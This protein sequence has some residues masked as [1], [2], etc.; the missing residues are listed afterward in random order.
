MS[1]LDWSIIPEGKWS[2]WR[3]T[4]KWASLDEKAL[5]PY[6]CHL[7][8]KANPATE[9]GVFSYARSGNERVVAFALHVARSHREVAVRDS[10]RR[11]LLQ[12]LIA[13]G[14][15]RRLVRLALKCNPVCV[16]MNDVDGENPYHTAASVVDGTYVEELSRPIRSRASVRPFYQAPCQLLPARSCD[17]RNYEGWAPIHKAVEK[18]LETGL[19]GA[20]RAL[21][22]RC[23]V[24]MNV[25]RGGDGYTVAHMCASSYDAAILDMCLSLNTDPRVRSEKGETITHMSKRHVDLLRVCARYLR[26][27]NFGW[28][29]DTG[30][31]ET[32]DDDDAYYRVATV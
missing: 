22:S 30:D 6:R 11:T 25:R 9:P 28:W 13:H 17:E 2:E 23:R 31:E 26:R 21:A 8:F 12:V 5:L 20:T 15:S 19:T 10:R 1:D 7:W 29:E 24:D 18:S 16:L 14:C 27:V 4:V 32:N 3:K